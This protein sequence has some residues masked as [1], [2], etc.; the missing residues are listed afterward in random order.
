[1]NFEDLSRELIRELR[2]QRSQTALSRRLGYRS[3]VVYRWEAGKRWPNAAEWFR[4]LVRVQ[5]PIAE[6]LACL[7]PDLDR[8]ARKG[9]PPGSHQ[10]LHTLLSSLS[11]H[12]ANHLASL[13]GIPAYSVRRMLRGAT[14]PSLPIFLKLVSVATGR[15]VPFLEGVRVELA[16]STALTSARP[17]PTAS[18]AAEVVAL[19]PTGDAGHGA[20]DVDVDRLAL[21]KV[22]PA[23]DLAPL[24]VDDH[25]RRGFLDPASLC[26]GANPNLADFPAGWADAGK[27][28]RLPECMP[29]S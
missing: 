13:T 7:G 20:E 26:E 27:A 9:G 6:A 24:L 22:E 18:P 12:S 11:D 14:Q 2:G 23:L 1:M 8:R 3:N 29:T 28:L 17:T 25:L 16:V 5:A 19:M 10:H 15:L 21:P 4:L